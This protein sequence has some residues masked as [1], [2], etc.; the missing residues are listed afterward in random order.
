MITAVAPVFRPNHAGLFGI[1]AID[2]SIKDLVDNLVASRAQVDP[3]TKVSDWSATTDEHGVYL[4]HSRGLDLAKRRSIED[5]FPRLEG[6]SE[7]YYQLNQEQDGH[8]GQ[9]RKIDYGD[10]RHIGLLWAIPYPDLKTQFLQK[11]STW[12]IISFTLLL[13]A[14]AG[15]IAGLL[16]HFVLDPLYTITDATRS[17][18]RRDYDDSDLPITIIRRQ[19]E[20]GELAKAFKTMVGQIRSDE[21]KLTQ[22]NQYLEQQVWER[23]KE[24]EKQKAD[25]RKKNMELAIARDNILKASRSKD[26][27]FAKMGHEI[28]NPLQVIT[29]AAEDLEEELDDEDLGMDVQDI[30]VSAWSLNEQ[31]DSMMAFSK[32]K[33]GKMQVDLT[34]FSV[35]E[36]VLGELENP[37]R[38]LA[39]YRN[40]RF[41]VHV[42]EDVDVITADRRWVQ[43]ALINL[44]NNACKFTKDGE[45]SLNVSRGKRSCSVPGLRY[46]YRY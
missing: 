29:L 5:N 21:E 22:A 33:A 23:T 40:N 44:L 24:L 7:S 25:L 32:S 9:F 36:L 28:R 11:D 45:I 1:I 19:D 27:F 35:P 41:R 3:D 8:V 18:A 12:K 14:G 38:R 10:H 34:E 31:V 6:L 37:I 46:R 39:E 2:M 30:L 20:V 15:I 16:I 42:A 4:A 43:N 17:F 26:E 13:I